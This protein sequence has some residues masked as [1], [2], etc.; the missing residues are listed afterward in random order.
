MK[1]LVVSAYYPPHHIG[2]YELGC[3]DVVNRLR[4]RGHTVRV[5]AGDFRY[6]N[7]AHPEEPEVYRELRRDAPGKPLAKRR[8]N[9]VLTEHLRA[10]GPDIVYFWS[11]SELCLW[12]PFVAA[13]H[14]YP[15]AFF[16]SDP[17]FI[18]WRVG[19]W[20]RG[21][22]KKN[23][24]MRGLFG[25]TFLVNG[26]PAIQNHAC[27]FASE[28]LAGVARKYEIPVWEANSIIAHWGIEKSDFPR[29]DRGNRPVRHL[30]YVGQLIPQKGVHTAIAALE[31]LT[32]EGAFSGCTL[33]I[34]GGGM[35]PDYEKRLR[36]QAAQ[37]GLAGKVQFLGRV[38]RAELSRIYAEHD[39]LIFP[40]EWDEPFAITPLEAMASGL[41][42][43]GTLTGGSPELFRNRE[44]AMTF[45]AG[46]A[47]DCARAIRE[48]AGDD[49]LRERITQTARNIVLKQHTLDVMLD[50]IEGSLK[51]IVAG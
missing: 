49:A 3:R 24:L 4:R 10:F 28:F 21:P 32:R 18:A 31:I 47:A 7:N 38:P 29:A 27:H 20:L 12:L 48:L 33:S 43:I 51:K 26:W 45:Q 13:A 9:G 50:A 14:G 34:A 35:N 41:P 22:A 37:S 11:Q 25:R 5:L 19:A 15:I 46:D 1:I 30:L 44:T 40:S 39:A 2:G 42:V 23:A 16:L 17:A 8:E 6:E 36:D